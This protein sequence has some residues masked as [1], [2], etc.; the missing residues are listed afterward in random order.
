MVGGAVGG[1]A[2]A[3]RWG[4]RLFDVDFYAPE[5]DARA[6]GNERQRPHAP[7]Q[8]SGSAARRSGAAG[9]STV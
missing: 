1:G 8:P 2:E 9:P 3:A 5:G 7:E 4:A 6:R